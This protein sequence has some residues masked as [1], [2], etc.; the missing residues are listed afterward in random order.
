MGRGA[1]FHILFMV[2]SA[3]V[4]ANFISSV[5]TLYGEINEKSAEDRLKVNQAVLSAHRHQV[6]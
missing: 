6:P 5:T 4:F 2:F 3:C 1:R